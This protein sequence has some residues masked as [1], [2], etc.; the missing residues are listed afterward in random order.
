MTRQNTTLRQKIF[1]VL[2]GLILSLLI[3]KIIFRV[4]GFF[5]LAAIEHRNKVCLTKYEGGFRIMFLGESTTVEGGW[6]SYPRQLGR[7]LREKLPD[8]GITII[9]KG[10]P[11]TNTPYIVSKLEYNLDK[12][13][14]DMVVTM[15][16]I[17]DGVYLIPQEE[18]VLGKIKS[19]I[20]TTR[21]Y[22]LAKFFL[23]RTQERYT[24]K[25]IYFERARWW[26]DH[27]NYPKA[28]K[29]FRKAI[30]LDPKAY[31]AYMEFGKYYQSRHDYLAAEEMFKK[32]IELAPYRK[33]PYFEIA[34][35]YSGQG[36][37]YQAEKMFK[38]ALEIEPKD[39]NIYLGLGWHY[40]SLRDYS[41][42]EKMF[43]KAIALNPEV[44]NSYFEAGGFYNQQGAYL[45]AQEMFKKA[46]E[47]NPKVSNSYLEAGCFY[48]QQ[49]AYLEAQ[50]MF[51]KAIELSPDDS[52]AYF[53]LGDCYSKQGKQTQAEEILQKAIKIFPHEKRGYIILGQC[54]TKQGR[55][56]QAEEMF[57]KA[58]ALNPEDD[59]GYEDL[60]L[61]YRGQ[62]KYSHG[63]SIRKEWIRIFRDTDNYSSITRHNYNRLKEIVLRRG[64]KLV[65]V[66]YPRRRLDSLKK[67]LNYDKNIIFVDNEKVFNEAIEKR[68]YEDYFEDRFASDF[69]H[70][71]PKGNWLLASNVAEVLINEYFHK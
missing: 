10:V 70:C 18:G 61:F 63:E 57:K 12:Y 16:G 15:M 39:Q 59:T 60:E 49:G 3:I 54:Y 24:L 25:Q 30:E 19:Y 31:D 1:L 23:L 48:D 64:I 11:D 65:C 26:Q 27:H 45:E 34:R 28:E 37:A 32:A 55:F 13:K 40:D 41:K 20:S 14:P 33:E 2:F 6:D 51:K 56:L 38:K 71:T 42:A 8:M 5:Y 7:I 4:G 9:N 68:V 17:N 43:K 47:I 69:G 67:I 36:Q 58:I 29:M 53:G 50:E 21:L 62:H 44:S 66:Q 46:I 22:K 52:G 35:Y